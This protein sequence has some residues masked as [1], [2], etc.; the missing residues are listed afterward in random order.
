MNDITEI[1]SV[2]ISCGGRLKQRHRQSPKDMTRWILE[3]ISLLDTSGQT[4]MILNELKATGFGSDDTNRS[5][6]YQLY[7]LTE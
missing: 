3:Q 7:R 6:E 2:N 1:V 4:M 5:N